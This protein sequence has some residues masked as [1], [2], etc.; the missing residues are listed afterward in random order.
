LIAKGE[1]ETGNDY[2]EWMISQNEAYRDNGEKR[3]TQEVA[4]KSCINSPSELKNL[5]TAKWKL[6]VNFAA[7]AGNLK[8]IIHAVERIASEGKGAQ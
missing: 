7:K 1:K 6:A 4:E 5:K 8:S 2:A 3:L